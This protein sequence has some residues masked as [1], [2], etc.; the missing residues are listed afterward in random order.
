MN[1]KILAITVIAIAAFVVQAQA[2]HSF[3]MFDKDKTI[4]LSGTVKE[5]EWSNPHCWLHITVADPA[6]GK[7]VAWAF[8]MGSITQIAAQGFKVDTVKVGD[9]VTVTG[10]PLKDGSHGG[11]FETVKLPDG[12]TL[13]N[14][15]DPG[16]DVPK[17]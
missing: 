14:A 5:Y 13:K 17:P 7:N 10:H 8:E 11:Q 16:P 12:R 2:H 6:T 3:S 1:W 15:V 9:K 4:T